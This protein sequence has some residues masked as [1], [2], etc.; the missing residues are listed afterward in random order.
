MYTYIMVFNRSFL[1]TFIFSCLI[2]CVILFKPLLVFSE[3]MIVLLRSPHLTDMKQTAHS[4]RKQ[5]MVIHHRYSPHILQGRVEN[6]GS[7]HSDD[8]NILLATNEPVS[9]GVSAQ[10][11]AYYQRI[12]TV[13]N[14]SFREQPRQLQP[15]QSLPPILNDMRLPEDTAQRHH[16]RGAPLKAPDGVGSLDTSEYMIGSIRLSV[17]LPESDCVS[18]TQ[19]WTSDEI[20][21]VMNE[22]AVGTQFWVDQN[23]QAFIE[24]DIAYLYHDPDN[25]DPSS[26]ALISIEPIEYSSY[27]DYV[28]INEVM[29]NLGYTS[30]QSYDYLDQTREYDRDQR[31]A[32]GTNWAVTVFVVD[33]SEDSDGCFSDGACAYS[34]LGGPLLVM[35]YDNNGYGISNMDYVVAHELA[36]SFW[37]L[38]EY[39]ES[40]GYWNNEG[41]RSGYLNIINGNF[42]TY[43]KTAT[44]ECI[45]RNID[46]WTHDE[47]ICVFTQ[48]QVGWRDTDGDGILDIIDTLNLDINEDELSFTSSVMEIIGTASVLPAYTNE[49]SLKE[50]MYEDYYG[51]SDVLNDISIL[52]ISNIQYRLDE[53]P[54]INT[55]P[56]D[57]SFDGT[58]ESFFT[59]VTLP[60][61]RFPN[62]Q[63][64]MVDS[65]G[66]STVSSLDVYSIPVNFNTT[67]E[68]TVPALGGVLE[69]T[70]PA[71]SFSE[72]LFL[73]V[74]TSITFPTPVCNSGIM[75]PTGVGATIVT[76][77]GEKPAQP[78]TL[79]FTCPD[80]SIGGMNESNLAVSYYDEE[81]SSWVDLA[82]NV[83]TSTNK[84][85]APT[86]HF[87]MFQ[88]MEMQPAATLGQ[89]KAYPNPF[90]LSKG[91]TQV[92]FTLLTEQ[93][94]IK[95]Y[96]LLGELVKIIEEIDADGRAYW[97]VRNTAGKKVA[98]GT[99]IFRAT[100]NEGSE[101]QGRVIV[102]K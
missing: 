86:D 80:A 31:N 10:L 18:E 50:E 11:P 99:Y 68:Y 69:I 92:V 23:P 67:S 34:Y 81:W 43:A 4:L 52:S 24:W 73:I 16:H 13:W 46:G 101:T 100:N 25:P 1:Y 62:I 83:D 3:E 36:H 96:T 22:I 40:W 9:T 8:P 26:A 64:R 53:D 51:L 45:M 54:W 85:S 72:D 87:S 6:A 35:T 95:I 2:V 84:V 58:S 77:T 59:S 55:T 61:G 27:L 30:Y 38:D 12:I 75:N 44:Y 102:I 70:V 66:N 97:D 76:S 98:T 37:A 78:I 21:N 14:N 20:T 90:N 28:W 42:E 39:Y 74:S 65:L 41:T 15:K 17:I 79:T 89:V 49:N 29:D 47:P 94:T 32:Q 33:S 56:D 7:F 82:S 60:Q 88:V 19:D 63:V 91:H 57:G 5:G 71:Y 93:A 48:E